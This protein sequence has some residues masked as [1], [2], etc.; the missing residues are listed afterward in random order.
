MLRKLIII[1]ILMQFSSPS[2]ARDRNSAAAVSAAAANL[3]AKANLELGKRYE[4][5][6]GVSR[7]FTR[8]RELY[9]EAARLGVADAYFE[10]GWM[11]LN[12]R[13]VT[14]DDSVSVFWLR[15]AAD[16]GIPQAVNILRL[17]S[18]TAGTPKSSCAPTLDRQLHASREM[19]ALVAAKAHAA[20]IDSRL[21]MAVISA[22]SGFDP[23]AV[24]AKNARGLMQLTADTAK[25]FG[26]Q[27]PFNIEE[28]LRG[29]ISFLGYLIERFNGDV[30]LALAAYNAGEGAID[31]WGGIPPYAETINYVKRV[32]SIC[33]CS[34]TADVRL[35][36]VIRSLSDP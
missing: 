26:V 21:V 13:G 28:N 35:R 16:H 32:K 11:Y 3:S 19:R 12:G 27:N 7:D 23:A 9:C 25:R 4:H 31:E 6:E 2:F 1:L 30:E 14:R 20:G 17:L 22:E 15:E 34:S 8:A 18:A 29:G 36:G 10:L 5:G 33:A 24:S